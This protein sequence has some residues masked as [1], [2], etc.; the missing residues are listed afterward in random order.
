MFSALNWFVSNWYRKR[1]SIWNQLSG[2]PPKASYQL[3]YVVADF[4]AIQQQQREEANESEH[5]H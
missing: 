3:Y 5:V 2:Q 4:I 1:V